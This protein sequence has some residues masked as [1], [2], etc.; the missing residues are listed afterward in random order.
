MGTGSTKS[1]HAQCECR[2]ER[3]LPRAF[4]VQ[5]RAPA[6]AVARMT[7]LGNRDPHSGAA[8]LF[9]AALNGLEAYAYSGGELTW[10]RRSA[11]STASAPLNTAPV[12]RAP[13]GRPAATRRHELAGRSAAG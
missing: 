3:T 11:A 2:E 12:P 5:E 8:R 4:M 10:P 9:M 6:S 7:R 1:G 13:R